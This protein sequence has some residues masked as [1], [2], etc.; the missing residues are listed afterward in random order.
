MDTTN[1]DIFGKNVVKYKSLNLTDRLLYFFL[2]ISIIGNYL[3]RFEAFPIIDTLLQLA[4]V[5][6]MLLIFILRLKHFYI[7]TYYNLFLLLIYGYLCYISILKGNFYRSIILIPLML[8]ALQLLYGK[9]IQNNPGWC[10]KIIS[11]IFLLFFILN[12]IQ[13]IF[14]PDIF[15]AASNLSKS[16]LI[17]TNY[18]QF[19]GAIIPGLLASCGG[20]YFDKSYKSRFLLMLFISVFMVTYAGSVTSSIA[21]LLIV[22]Y[23]FFAKSNNIV[24]NLFFIGIIFGI[25]FIFVD[26]VLQ[27]SNI[28]PTGGLTEKFFD[29]VGKEA[30]FSGR[31]YIW[32][33][34]MINI[35]RHPITGVGWYD[36]DWAELNIHGVNPHNLILNLLLQGGIVLLLIVVTGIALLIRSLLKKKEHSSRLPIFISLCY[37]LMLQFEVYNYFMISLS[38]LLLFL[39]NNSLKYGKQIHL[40]N[41]HPSL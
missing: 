20:M 36:K 25:I 9:L 34:T 40:H 8:V 30:T 37:F 18:N 1:I 2:S 6:S 16:Y 12:T 4:A 27:T 11:D 41:N 17:S 21:L 22:I 33:Y 31:S 14:L 39:F 7:F 5:F 3:L 23:Y 29:M 35:I 13:M 24:N 32:A 26:F 28:F 15:P 10:F 19:G 38:V